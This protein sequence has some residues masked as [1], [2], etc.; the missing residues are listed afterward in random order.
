MQVSKDKLPCI[1]GNCEYRCVLRLI[2]LM[3]QILKNGK[4]GRK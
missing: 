1:A 2:T 4:M 3:M